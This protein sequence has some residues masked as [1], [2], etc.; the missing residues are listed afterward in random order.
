MS[1]FHATEYTVFVWFRD[2]RSDRP[3]ISYK[4][5]DVENRELA[6]DLAEHFFREGVRFEENGSEFIFHPSQIVYTEASRKRVYTETEQETLRKTGFRDE[7][8]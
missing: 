6:R 2:I 5:F 7:R 3:L 4:K 1:D 8:H